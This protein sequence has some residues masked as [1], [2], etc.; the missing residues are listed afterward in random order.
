MDG[1]LYNSGRPERDLRLESPSSTPGVAAVGLRYDASCP[2]IERVFLAALG[3][4]TRVLAV[5]GHAAEPGRAALARALAERCALAG[6]RTLLLDLSGAHGGPGA[7]AG[8][9]PGDGRAAISIERDDTGYDRLVAAG[10]PMAAMRLR[11]LEGLKRLLEEELALYRT[12]VVDAGDI[13]GQP[14]SLVPAA[15]SVQACDGIVV[16]TAPNRVARHDFEH[17][18]EALGP[19]RKRVIGLVIDDSRNPTVGAQMLEQARRLTSRLPRIGR[20]LERRIER[21]RL[22]WVNV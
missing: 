9:T 3:A 10:S 6:H 17:A 20:F 19:A 21:A 18:L 5:A 2:R 8:W 22:L 4:D 1:L 13:A 14:T 15:T 7:K 12:I 11:S 16:V